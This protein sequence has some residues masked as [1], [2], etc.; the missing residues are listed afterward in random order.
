M[1][2]I[3]NVSNLY[4]GGGVQVAISLLNELRFI[5]ANNEYNIFLS[6]PIENQIEKQLFSENF[7]FFIIAKPASYL[8]TR[9]KII[10]KL[11]ELEDQINPDIVITLFGPS[12]WKPKVKSLMGF[13]DPWVLN[14]NSVAYKELNFYQRIQKRLINLY[15]IYYLKRETSYYIIETNNAKTKL[16]NLLNIKDDQVYVIGNCYSNVFNNKELLDYNSKDFIKLPKKEPDEF[17]LV[18]ISHNY[19]HKNLKIIQ[20][21]IPLIKSYNV[22]FIVTIDNKYYD[23]LFF[24]MDNHVMNLGPVR[25]KSV[26]SIYSQ[27]DALFL[28]TLLEV[29]SASYPEA[30]K[31]QIPILTSNYS[32]AEEICKDAAL[33]FDPLDPKDIS[34]KII[35]LINSKKLQKLLKENGK[36]R[37]QNFETARSR[38]KKYL[39]ICNIV[40]NM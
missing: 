32:F 36:R 9:F 4:Y 27:C 16:L 26:P 13:A 31:M 17:R 2:I 21:I 11:N 33:Y 7:K 18:L 29:F 40:V 6:K 28:P 20:K 5:E 10:K 12:Y 19:S 3:I 35:E 1:K 39:K 24:G 14:Q 22:K 23:E 15:K 34:E 25:I 30:M 8:N 37:I 38:A